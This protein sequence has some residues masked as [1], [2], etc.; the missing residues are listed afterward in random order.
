MTDR[1]IDRFL[2]FIRELQGFEARGWQLVPSGDGAFMY[3][4]SPLGDYTI[5]H[6]LYGEMF[7]NITDSVCNPHYWEGVDAIRERL[8]EGVS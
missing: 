8:P 1:A 4:K 5:P 2:R 7:F 6:G 3:M